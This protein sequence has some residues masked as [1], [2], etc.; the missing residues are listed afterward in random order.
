LIETPNATG[1]PDKAHVD[2]LILPDKLGQNINMSGASQGRDPTGT[3]ILLENP[4]EYQGTTYSQSGWDRMDKGEQVSNASS[5]ALPLNEPKS[6]VDHLRRS[7]RYSM[8]AA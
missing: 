3:A 4:V 1:R 7:L 2:L 5:I 6:Y 8:P